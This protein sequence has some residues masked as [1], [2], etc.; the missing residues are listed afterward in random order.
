MKPNRFTTLLVACAA[1]SFLFAQQTNTNTGIPNKIAAAT[2]APVPGSA[3]P[4]SGAGSVTLP[5]GTRLVPATPGGPVGANTT[6]YSL[7]E[8]L[9]WRPKD[10]SADVTPGDAVNAQKAAMLDTSAGMPQGGPGGGMPS[11]DDILGSIADKMPGMPGQEKKKVVKPGEDGLEANVDPSKYLGVQSRGKASDLAAANRL[12]LVPAGTIITIRSY[13]RINTS[14]GGTCVAVIDHDV[15]DAQMTCVVIPR[16]SKL[17][18]TIQAVGSVAQSRAS[19]VFRQIVDPEGNQIQLLVPAPVVDRIG[20]GGVAGKVD[21]HWGM[22]VGVATAYAV[23]GGLAS[24]STS[25]N[26]SGMNFQSAVQ[27]NISQQFGQMG[28]SALQEYMSLKP[29]IEVPENTA[30]RIIVGGPIYAKPWRVLRPY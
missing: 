24:T 17:L 8:G 14:L 13:T 5:D 29:D 26:S 1:G 7:S 10:V 28:T 15:K 3:A 12:A 4:Q 27:N 22:K 18:G 23:I 6:P 20:A 21:G 11:M 2:K 19:V 25:T 16:G 9:G 30:L